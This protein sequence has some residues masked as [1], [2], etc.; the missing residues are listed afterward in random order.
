MNETL[1]LGA[2]RDALSSLRESVADVEVRGN[3]QKHVPEYKVWAFG[4]RTKGT[5]KHDSD[6]DLA[7]ISDH[8]LS[9]AVSA[10]LDDDFTESDL[11]WKVDVVDWVTTSRYIKYTYHPLYKRAILFLFI[12]NFRSGLHNVLLQD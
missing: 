3:L 4:S 9:L 8:A 1:D 5:A 7:V 6:I 10:S 2:L 12:L 11:P